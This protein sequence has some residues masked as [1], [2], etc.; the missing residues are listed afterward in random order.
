MTMSPSGTNPLWQYLKT[1]YALDL[2]ALSVMRVGMALILLF[3]LFLQSFDI[4]AFY[5]DT[6]I[7][8]RSSALPSRG[9]FIIPFHFA[10]GTVGVEAMLFLVAAIFAIMLLFGYKTRIAT[11]A[12]WLMLIS[13]QDRNPLLF[14]GGDFELAQ[15]LFWSMFLPLNVYWSVDAALNDDPAL[16]SQSIEL[17]P[18]REKTHSSL[19]GMGLFLLV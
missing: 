11:I 6:G 19:A 4:T 14:F 2:R 1:S 10:S 15:M 8:P 18:H 13:M 7:L 9:E 3:D 12:S 17:K 16:T 5:T